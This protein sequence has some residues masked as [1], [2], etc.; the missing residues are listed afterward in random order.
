MGF[1]LFLPK[2]KILSS[3]L[4]IEEA[5]KAIMPG[6]IVT[7]PESLGFPLS[8]FRNRLLKEKKPIENFDG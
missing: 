8:S 3:Q 6:G 1:L 5:I 4:T 7:P 2:E